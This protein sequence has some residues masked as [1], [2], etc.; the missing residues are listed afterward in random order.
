MRST[1]KS[2]KARDR[3]NTPAAIVLR[4]LKSVPNFRREW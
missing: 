1:G 3:V 4:Y 2:G